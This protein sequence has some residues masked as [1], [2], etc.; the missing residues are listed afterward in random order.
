M[1]VCYVEIQKHMGICKNTLEVW[2]SM[3][4]SGVLSTL[5][6]C[7]Y[8]SPSASITQH[9]TLTSALFLL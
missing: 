3:M 7:S 1:S 2:R 5:L 6:E 8:K 9:S 4:C